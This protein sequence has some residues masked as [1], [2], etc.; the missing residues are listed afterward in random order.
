MNWKRSLSLARISIRKRKSR[1]DRGYRMVEIL[2]QGQ[3]QPLETVDEVLIIYAGT[4][5]FLDKV[6]RREVPAWEK[7]FL[8]YIRDQKGEIRKKIVDTKDLDEATIQA[9]NAAIGEFQ[10][11]YAAKHGDKTTVRV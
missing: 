11:L 1:L 6:P 10:R 2:K 3:F 8:T 9:I 5:G 7:E 4:R